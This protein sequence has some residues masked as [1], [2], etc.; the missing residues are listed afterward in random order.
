[1]FKKQQTTDSYRIKEKYDELYEGE[2]LKKGHD[3]RG[4]NLHLHPRSYII[5]VA[6]PK[7][8]K[9]QQALILDIGTGI[10]Y[11]LELANDVLKGDA[12]LIGSDLSINALRRAKV[13]APVF[14]ADATRLPVKDGIIDNILCLDVI[15]HIP[16]RQELFNELARVLK[17]GGKLFISVPNKY[18]LFP[19]VER[20]LS[21]KTLIS[22]SFQPFDSPL[23][24]F[25]LKTHLRNKFTIEECRTM[26]VISQRVRRILPFT[27]SINN[28]LATRYPLRYF[29]EFLVVVAK[30]V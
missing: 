24:Y 15:E 9:Q 18:Y 11:S 5:R 29:G 13:H 20:L 3:W 26:S 27:E 1:M 8:L 16:H 6:L 4:S 12:I 17:K 14:C 10:G 25:E 30:K 7:N 19:L 28:Y 2:L 22:S 21:I 23:S